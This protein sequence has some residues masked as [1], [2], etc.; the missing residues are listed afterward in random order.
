MP[1]HG[2]VVTLAGLDVHEAR[3]LRRWSP[4]AQTWFVDIEPRGLRAI[5]AVW[6]EAR[7]YHGWLHRFL[8]T[9]APIRFFHADFM[10]PYSQ[11]VADTMRAARGRLASGA[12]IALTFLR[13]RDGRWGQR[14]RDL[15]SEVDDPAIRRWIGTRRALEEDLGVRLDVLDAFEYRRTIH[16]PMGSLVAR[17]S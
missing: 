12:I 2:D 6:P 17:V 8:A 7:I 10:G 5:Q 16:S 13:C 3:L 1:A 15:A 9:A 14:V 4:P 11:R